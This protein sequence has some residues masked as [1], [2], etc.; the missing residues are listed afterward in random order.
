MGKNVQMIV[1][2]SDRVTLKCAN[3]WDE[4]SNNGERQKD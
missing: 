1:T 4:I 3:Y 2:V